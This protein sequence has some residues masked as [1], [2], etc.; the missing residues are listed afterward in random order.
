LNQNFHFPEAAKVY[1]IYNND[2]ICRASQC[3]KVYVAMWRR[4]FW[5]IKSATKNNWNAL[6]YQEVALCINISFDHNKWQKQC[7]IFP[8]ELVGLWRSR[9]SPQC[10]QRFKSSGMWCCVVC[11]GLKDF[12]AFTFRKQAMEE[13]VWHRERGCVM[14][15]WMIMVMKGNV[16]RQHEW[17]WYAGNGARWWKWHTQYLSHISEDFSLQQVGLFV[18]I[19]QLIRCLPN[20][21]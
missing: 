21:R 5:K 20:V 3:R 14:L 12:I 1:V 9:Y 11:L 7:F 18:N 19:T 6:R 16:V 13:G 15:A 10:C 8:P 2:S 17:H 4:F